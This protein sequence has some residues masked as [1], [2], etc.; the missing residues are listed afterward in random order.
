MRDKISDILKR[1]YGRIVIPESDGRFRAEIIEFAGCLALANT[2]A[3]AL[4]QIEEVAASW[5]EAVIDKGQGIPK[6]IGETGFSGK[7]V[8]RLPKDL[9]RKAAYIAARE[10]VS[11]N[12]F[13]LNSV[14][15]QI[16]ALLDGSL[17]EGEEK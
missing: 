7:L 13:I 10:G 12:Q 17:N 8:V 2:A 4:T 5:L 14:A 9:H 11:L 15:E 3:E 1:P 6:P 16:G